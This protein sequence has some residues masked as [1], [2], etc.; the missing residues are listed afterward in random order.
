MT[1]SSPGFPYLL[2]LFLIG[3]G[4]SLSV[5]YLI[6]ISPI[7]A[8]FSLVINCLVIIIIF[9]F[10]ALANFAPEFSKLFLE[11]QPESLKVIC[12]L[13]AISIFLGAILAWVN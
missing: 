11:S 5:N 4:G 10:L 8:T 1:P 9:L 2:S 6:R 12:C 13:I 7:F 3:L